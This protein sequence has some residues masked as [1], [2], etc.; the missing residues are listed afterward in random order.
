MI[1]GSVPAL[2][3]SHLADGPPDR[4]HQPGNRT[5]V[6][7]IPRRRWCSS[8]RL[9]FGRTRARDGLAHAAGLALSLSHRLDCGSSAPPDQP[10]ARIFSSAFGPSGPLALDSAGAP[11]GG[12]IF[13]EKLI[14]KDNADDVARTLFARSRGQPDSFDQRITYPPFTG[15]SGVAEAFGGCA[16]L[17]RSRRIRVGIEGRALY[18]TDTRKA[19]HGTL[20]NPLFRCVIVSVPAFCHWSERSPLGP[21]C[22]NL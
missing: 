4:A 19:N 13:Q 20:T 17:R 10:P 18:A 11:V 1:F 22:C 5:K 15:A 3:Y 14:P 6:N 21:S 12:G 9:L 8:A 16:L 2:T 7:E